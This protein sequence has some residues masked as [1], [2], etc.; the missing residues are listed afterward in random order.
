MTHKTT[1]SEKK[2]LVA[3]PGCDHPVHLYPRPRLD[4]LRA[5]C[6]FIAYAPPN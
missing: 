4:W 1:R 6:Y 3:I 5:I 2:E